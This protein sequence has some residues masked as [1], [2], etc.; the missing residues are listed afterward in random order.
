MTDKEI[1]VKWRSGL[2][3]DKLAILYKRE[4][5][6]QI[7]IIRST[8]RHRYD[9]KLINNY[10]ALEKIEKVIYQYIKSSNGKKQNSTH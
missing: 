3:K 1:I 10:E 2:S 6:Q 8:V 4:Y 9:G 7:K 5:N